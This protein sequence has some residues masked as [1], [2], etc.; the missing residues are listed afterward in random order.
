MTLQLKD[1]LQTMK[2]TYSFVVKIACEK[3][4]EEYCEPNMK[5]LD[6]ILTGKGMTKRTAPKALPLAAQPLAF[7]RLQG[8]VG[9]YY[10]WEM[11]FDYPVTPTELTAEICSILGISKA[12][13][14]VRTAENPFN[15]IE[16]DYL[17][18][19]EKDYIPQLI[20]DEMPG[21]I[22]EEDLVGDEYNKQL[23]KKLQSKEAKQYQQEFKEV[24]KKMYN[25]AE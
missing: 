13:V 5:R 1:I 21:K 4:F 20:T 8:F 22:N 2:K 24:D 12:F 3:T 25:G 7:Q 15:K 11:E 17:K 6:T 23:V 9:T 18:Y 16:E 14:V 19:D 10:Q